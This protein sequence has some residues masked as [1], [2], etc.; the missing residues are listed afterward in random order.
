MRQPKEAQQGV[1]PK[2]LPTDLWP[3]FH[4]LCPNIFHSD[5]SGRATA[6]GRLAVIGQ[7]LLVSFKPK[8]N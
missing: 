5:K 7:R 3:T 6:F 4:Q 1:L 8:G 2:I